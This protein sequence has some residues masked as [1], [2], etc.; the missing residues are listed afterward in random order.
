M[1]ARMKTTEPAVESVSSG[2][3]VGL[4]ENIKNGS[5]SSTQLMT[6]V[7]ELESIGEFRAACNLFALWLDSYKGGHRHIFLYNYGS[8]LQK[9]KNFNEAVVAYKSS[10]KLCPEF[11]QAYINLGL[12]YEKIGNQLA[13]LQI[14][15]HLIDRRGTKKPPESEF[16]IVAL[17]NIGRLQEVLNNYAQSEHALAMSLG[18]NPDQPGV[19]QHL[20][21]IRQKACSWPIYR[22]LAGVSFENMKRYTSPLAMLAYTEEPS[23]QLLCSQAFCQRTYAFKEERLSEGRVYKHKR[24]RVGYVSGDFREHAV[25]FLV[26]SLVQGHDKAKFELFAYD[27]S[28]EEKTLLRSKLKNIFEHFKSIGELS[29]RQAA[30]LMLSDEIDILID[31]HGLSSG[32]RPGIFALH[33]A[34]RQGSYL[35]FMGPTGMPWLDFVIADQC[36]LP[37]ELVPHFTEK[38]LYVEDGFFPMVSYHDSKRV[39][40]R[41]ELGL[42]PDAFVMSSFSNTFKITQEMFGTWIRLLKYIPNSVLWLID[43]NKESTSNLK[44]H[45]LDQGVGPERLLFSPRVE[46]MDFC[47]RLKL[48]DVYLDT[49][50]YNSG[51]TSNDVIHAGVPIVTMYGKTLVSR[52]GLSLMTKINCTS[53][54]TQ[55]DRK[56][57]V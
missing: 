21:H 17:N 48:A 29:D 57:V 39:A 8:S 35:G 3:D 43:D 42:A 18:I 47:A 13:A 49:Y 37:N 46:H 5:M 32:A 26:P 22:Q 50:P 24:L 6:N 38:P 19:I 7:Q 36:V 34:P 30:E 41:G 10:I 12:L 2:K 15:L 25:G 14:W 54:A 11:S 52:M 33:P 56:S 44:A 27:F 31:L 23:E 16:V 9:D 55:T 53:S 4:L 20:V 40:T 51:S 1:N 28:L 45:A